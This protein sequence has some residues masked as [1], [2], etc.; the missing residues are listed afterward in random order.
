M[1]IE[2]DILNNF[3]CMLSTE[4]SVSDLNIESKNI[5]FACF[6]KIA[7]DV[8]NKFTYTLSTEDSLHSI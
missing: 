5:L 1:K 6:M 4:D 3:T 2:H 8:L 7:H